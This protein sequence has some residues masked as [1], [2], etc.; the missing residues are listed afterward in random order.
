M[1]SSRSG[2]F[3]LAAAGDA[4]QMRSLA[5]LDHDGFVPLVRRV[6]DADAS[7][8]NVEQVIANYDDGYPTGLPGGGEKIA[9]PRIVDD[10]E[11]AGFN[12]FGL[13]NNH[14]NDLLHGGMLATIR[15][16]EERN[17][18]HAGL[19]R[20]LGEARAPGFLECAAG[21]VALI[22]GVATPTPGSAAGL[23]RQDFTGRPGV[24]PLRTRT[25]YI[26]DDHHLGWLRELSEDLGL[27]EI[28]RRREE[29][30]TLSVPPDTDD[31]EFAL[32]T[33]HAEA[34]TGVG[35]LQFEQGDDVGIETRLDRQDAEEYI[36]RIAS[37]NEYSDWVIASLHLHEGSSGRMNHWP[38]E[39]NQ[40]FVQQC[41]DAGADAVVQ[42]GPHQLRGIDLYDGKPIFYSLN[43]W[44]QQVG[45]M[46]RLS[47][48]SYRQADL[49]TDALPGDV[50]RETA[51]EDGY[52]G[53]FPDS[54]WWESI[55][56]TCEYSADE[57]L[58][59]IELTPIDLQQ[60]EPIHRCGTPVRATGETAERIIDNLAEYSKPYG[61]QIEFED[62]LGVVDL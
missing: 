29:L 31:D 46:P 13:A 32:L 10:F 1:G 36:R 4:I 17:L 18:T 48:E 44:A 55:L 25:R 56:A 45:G 59:R 53:R 30:D 8:V 2:G 38:P 3:T 6:R 52:H 15:A 37:A 24:N 51:D 11:W 54:T 9:K 43:S 33:S 50:Y 22:A 34:L 41:I 16:F 39:Y 58:E 20:D 14:S 26:V 47:Q 40:E 49:G 27:D 42:H 28:R 19:G 61:T 5:V 21:R 35:P 57:T 62:G 60:H 12:L 7:F 23:R